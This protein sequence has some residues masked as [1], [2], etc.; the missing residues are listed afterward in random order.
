LTYFARE[1]WFAPLFRAVDNKAVM[2]PL[3]SRLP[4]FR[5]KISLKVKASVQQTVNFGKQKN[6]MVS[7]SIQLSGRIRFF[8]TLSGTHFIFVIGCV[9][10][11]AGGVPVGS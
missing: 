7:E 8:P 5:V 9:V 1:P 3:P 11:P 6:E 4:T 2:V 10:Q